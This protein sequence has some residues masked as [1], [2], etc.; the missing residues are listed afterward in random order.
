[1]L[2]TASIL[3]QI[4]II[5]SNLQQWYLEIRGTS[6]INARITDITSMFLASCNKRCLFLKSEGRKKHVKYSL[7]M[8]TD[9]WG[10]RLEM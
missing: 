3:K 2:N 1:M 6:Q 8:K 9:G 10:T 7:A 5:L 4:S